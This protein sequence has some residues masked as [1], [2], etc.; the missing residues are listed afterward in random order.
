[1]SDWICTAVHFVN[2]Q[3]QGEATRPADTQQ[4][5]LQDSPRT[6][7][8]VRVCTPTDPSVPAANRPIDAKEAVHEV[9]ST[10]GFSTL[11]QQHMKGS[12][13]GYSVILDTLD[14]SRHFLDHSRHFLDH[15]RHFLNHSRHFLDHSRHFLDTKEGQ[16]DMEVYIVGSYTTSWQPRWGSDKRPGTG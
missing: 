4:A 16:V 9:S 5:I 10:Q 13:K 3:E 6:P 14:H 7:A 2:S 8:A 15:S 12:F 1:M 11:K